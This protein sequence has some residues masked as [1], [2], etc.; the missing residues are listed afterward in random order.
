MAEG[1]ASTLPSMS[2]SSPAEPLGAVDEGEVFD[3][4][5]STGQMPA[6]GA[7]E[8]GA[9]WAKPWGQ[10]VPLL[11]W[12]PVMQRRNNA[13]MPPGGGA[14]A[15]HAHG[16]ISHQPGPQGQNHEITLL[17]LHANNAVTSPTLLCQHPGPNLPAV[18]H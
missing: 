18:T 2:V 5:A 3:H 16:G 1:K 9:P 6:E 4:L 17:C 7:P 8:R 12:A 10:E 13:W 15:P 11:L 14:H